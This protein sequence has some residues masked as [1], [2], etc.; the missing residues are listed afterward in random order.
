MDP[1]TAPV[2]LGVKFRA[3]QNGFVSGVRFYKGSGNTGTHTGSLWS[4]TGTKLGSVTFTNETASGWQ[5]AS[6]ASPIAVTAGT[7]YV[8]SYF[9][10]TGRYSVDNSYFASAATTSGPLT[11]LRNGTDG[12]NGVYRYGTTSGFPSTA[13]QSSNYWVDLV[14]TTG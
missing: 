7:T 8:V 3:T 5:Q 10:P 9:A 13:Y 12:S 14:F 1:D 11:A 6:F 2:E 4:R